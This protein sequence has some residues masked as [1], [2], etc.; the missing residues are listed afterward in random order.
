MAET[1]EGRVKRWLFGTRQKPGVL[2]Q[3]FPGARWDYAP[4]GGM[5]GS[6][7]AP[8]RLFVW[9][10]V[11]VGLEVKAEGGRATALQLENLKKIAEA[12]GVAAIIYGKDLAKLDAIYDAVMAKVRQYGT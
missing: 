5:F 3:K 2:W 6:T 9:R 11:F 7:G 12:G 8:D 4:P 1:P 10:G